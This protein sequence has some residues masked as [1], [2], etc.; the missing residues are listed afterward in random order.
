METKSLES[1]RQYLETLNVPKKHK[2]E[3]EDVLLGYELVCLAK[4]KRIK[5]LEKELEKERIRLAVCGAAALANTPESAKAARNMR[6]EYGSASLDDVI[7]IVDSEMALRK[8]N[9]ELKAHCDYLLNNCHVFTDTRLGE[10][11]AQAIEGCVDSLDWSKGIAPED[12]CDYAR[13]LRSKA[14]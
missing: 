3:L 6:K 7:R 9:D 13:G 14:E 5:E 11:K 10:L 8:E 4:D 2:A 12:L 1:V